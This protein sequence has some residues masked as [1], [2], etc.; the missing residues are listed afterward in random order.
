V[1]FVSDHGFQSCTRAVHMDRLLEG[2]GFLRFAVSK[3]VFGPMQWGP[4][5]AVARKVYDVLG[6]HGRVSLPQSVN[7]QKTVAYTSVR[8]TGEGVSVNLA[9][10]EPDGV[11]DP[12]DFEATRDKVREALDG[13]VDPDT[14]KKPMRRVLRREDVFTG[15]FAETAPDILLEPAPLYSLTHAR[16]MIEDADW[17]SGDHRMEGVLAAA[18]PRVAIGALAEPA[19]LIDMAPT[20]L[21]ALGVPASVKHDG[22]VLSSLVGDE[23]SVAAAGMREA[24]DG[25][26]E[27][28]GLAED[29]AQE[30]EE[31]LRGLGYLE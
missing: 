23:A 22:Q 9:G 16:S 15:R 5:R 27:D 8:S 31:H 1:L 18:G 28:T 19:R 29:E 17:L 10:R 7:W 3:A 13:F 24:D 4:M 14:G 12:A 21:A 11:V 25:P 20:I 26:S 30:V 6:L 2:L